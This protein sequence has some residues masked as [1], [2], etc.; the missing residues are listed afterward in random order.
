MLSK[1]SI[2]K[3]CTDKDL[4]YT[5]GDLDPTSEERD[6]FKTTY[7]DTVYKW[8]GDKNPIAKALGTGGNSSSAANSKVTNF[9]PYLCLSLL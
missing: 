6:A 4:N 9:C 3:L 5:S 2:K 8:Q 1:S 7:K